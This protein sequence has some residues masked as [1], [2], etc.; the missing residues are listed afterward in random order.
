MSNKY[1]DEGDIFWTFFGYI[2]QCFV[3]ESGKRA[4]PKNFN[5]CYDW[6]TV[7]IEGVE[8]VNNLNDCYEKAFAVPGDIETDNE[9]L[10]DDRV[11]ANANHIKLHPS[12]T[13]NNITY[14]NS[15]G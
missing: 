6:S 4:I 15:T 10:R 12:I 1:H 9:I 8:E 14:T 11:W 2:S 13:I 7:K 3:D 5:D